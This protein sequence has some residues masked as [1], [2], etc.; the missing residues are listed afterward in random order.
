MADGLIANF[1]Y[2]PAD[3]K[4][5]TLVRNIHQPLRAVHLVVWR[6]KASLA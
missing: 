3:R 1:R 6:T 2:L 5:A 4:S